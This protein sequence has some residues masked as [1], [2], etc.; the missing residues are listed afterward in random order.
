MTRE[1]PTVHPMLCKAYLILGSALVWTSCLVWALPL[2]EQI[3]GA[4]SG[5]IWYYWGFST[6]VILGLTYLH[7]SR[8]NKGYEWQALFYE[9]IDVDLDTLYLRVNQLMKMIGVIK[10]SE[11]KANSPEFRILWGLIANHNEKCKDPDCPLLIIQDLKIEKE[12]QL[13]E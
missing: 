3:I 9:D 5:S 1:P 6:P 12:D 11:L 8:F 13:I 7:S 4:S 10:K 2:I